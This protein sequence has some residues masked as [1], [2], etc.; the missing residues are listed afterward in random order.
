MYTNY[1][2]DTLGHNELYVLYNPT[3]IVLVCNVV[4][5]A[6]IDVSYAE[7]I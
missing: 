5:S 4:I 1:F 3:F 7:M 6:V 2:D